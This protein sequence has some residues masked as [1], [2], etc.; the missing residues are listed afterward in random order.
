MSKKNNIFNRYFDKIYVINLDDKTERWKEAQKQFNRRGIKAE[1]FSAVDGRCKND[2]QCYKKKKIFQK[3]YGVKIKNIELPTASLVIGTILILREVVKKK[4]KRVL[5]CEDDFQLG[6]N[7]FKK[8]E[9]GV[10]ELKKAEPNWEMLI[11]GCTQQCGTRGISKEMTK[12]NKHRTQLYKWLKKANHYVAHSDD[13]RNICND[14]RGYWK[15]SLKRRSGDWEDPENGGR[16]F[17]ERISKHLSKPSYPG[18]TWCYA[19]TL[20]GAKKILRI[21]DNKVD[22]HLDGYYME[23]I[24]DGTINAVA[25]D[26]PIVW[27]TGGAERTDSDIPW[28]W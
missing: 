20:E 2:Y 8:F 23:K 11:L 17:C 13:I 6:K 26:P 16:I 5:I 10:K 15:K 28:D 3:E 25:F 7:L 4:M 22:D 24:Q 9:V 12:I 18:G 1:R 27:H 14:Y 19:V 21:F